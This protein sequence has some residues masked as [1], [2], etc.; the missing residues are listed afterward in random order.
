MSRSGTS[1]LIHTRFVFFPHEAHFRCVVIGATKCSF[2][3]KRQLNNLFNDHNVQNSNLHVL[4]DVETFVDLA[5][6]EL[7]KSF[8]RGRPTTFLR[9]SRSDTFL[10]TDL[11]F[12]ACA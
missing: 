8:K 6:L 7:T 11:I 10:M 1:H 5:F 12:L 3:S 4:L 9:I 2:S